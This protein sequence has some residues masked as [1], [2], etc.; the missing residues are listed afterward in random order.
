MRLKQYILK[1]GQSGDIGA[2]KAS[3]SGYFTTA[4]FQGPE[5]T[6]ISAYPGKQHNK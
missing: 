3:L 6:L 1:Q 4:G 5:Y 2:Q